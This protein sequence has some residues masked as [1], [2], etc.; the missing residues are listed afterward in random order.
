MN[1][2]MLLRGKELGNTFAFGVYE[3]LTL[4]TE[5]KPLFSGLKIRFP[6]NILTAVSINTLVEPF[7]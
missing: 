3:T 1:S 6:R 5:E 7:L 2:N 4:A